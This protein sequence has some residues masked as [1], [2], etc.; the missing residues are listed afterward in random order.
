MDKTFDCVLCGSCVVD[1]LVRGVPLESPIGGGKLFPA[2]PVE[3]ATGGIVSNTGIAMTKLGMRTAAFSYVGRDEWAAVLRNRLASAGMDTSY[4]LEHPSEPT[5]TTGVLIDPSGERSFFHCVGAPLEMNGAMFRKHMDVFAR[6]RMAVIGYYSLMPRLEPDLPDVLAE[7]RRNGCVTVLDAA[8]EGGT[9]EP[10]ARILPNL[11]VYVPSR[12][13]AI[14]QTGQT[15][16]HRILE[17]F[18]ACGAPGVL[19]VKLGSDGALLSPAAG[20]YVKVDVIPAPGKVVDT[21]G[22]GDSF[23]AGLLAGLLKGMNLADAGRLAA[24]TGACCVTGLGASAGIRNFEETAKLAGI[25]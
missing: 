23:Y 1:L 11:D 17:T 19:G 20:E 6:S 9:L 7:V 22:A 15:D 13:E 24:A 25:R 18:R 21:T 3:V 8:G 16:P 12:A 14:H 10:L 5:S 2:Q 4:L